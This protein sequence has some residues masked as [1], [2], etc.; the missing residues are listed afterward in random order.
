MSAGALPQT[1]PGELTAL[2]RP[3]SQGGHFTGGEWRKGLGK[4][5]GRGKGEW[6]MGK[7]GMGKGGEKGELVGIAPCLLRD[8]HPCHQ[9]MPTR[10]GRCTEATRN[11]N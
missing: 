11:S 10:C 9:A 2:P 6:G 3:S 1:P 7:W 4:G 5:D 8:R